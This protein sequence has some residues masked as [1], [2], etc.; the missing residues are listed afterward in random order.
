MREA[1]G[2]IVVN[3]HEKSFLT[4]L[5]LYSYSGPHIIIY[6]ISIETPILMSTNMAVVFWYFPVHKL[7]VDDVS[8][9]S[10]TSGLLAVRF[11][12]CFITIKIIH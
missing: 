4:S 9:L 5:P 6:K 8:A 1:L 3:V 11:T 10:T 2:H 7:L 12:G